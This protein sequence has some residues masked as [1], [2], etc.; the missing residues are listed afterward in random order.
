[1]LYGRVRRA[2]NGLV[3]VFDD[4]FGKCCWNGLLANYV[5]VAVVLLVLLVL[6]VFTS[7]A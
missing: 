6:L 5:A 3:L 7:S 4:F 1:M 2:G